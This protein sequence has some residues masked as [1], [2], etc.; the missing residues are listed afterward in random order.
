M[1]P[2]MVVRFRTCAHFMS[3]VTLCG[4]ALGCLLASGCRAPKTTIAS[5]D[6]GPKDQWSRGVYLYTSNCAG[7]HGDHGEG[8][9][10]T[11]AIAGEGALPRLPA[12]EDSARDTEL[13][14]AADLFAYVKASMPPLDTGCLTDD[15]LYAVTNYLL[16]QAE[17]DFEGDVTPKTA[18]RIRLR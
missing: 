10:D 9:E 5:S 3:F 17:I 11:P 4:L 7:C 15:Q 13:D 16:K 1:R 2:V 6:D 14:T 8:D 18:S 12:H